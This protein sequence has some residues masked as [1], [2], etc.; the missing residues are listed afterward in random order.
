MS[1]KPHSSVR[2]S[3]AYKASQKRLA[4]MQEKMIE[5]KVTKEKE[6]NNKRLEKLFESPKKDGAEGT[7]LLSRL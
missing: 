1:R 2:D 7:S 6:D 3:K 4:K 5:K